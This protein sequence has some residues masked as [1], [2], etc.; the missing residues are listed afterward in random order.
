MNAC[1][2]DMLHDT[3]HNSCCSVRK[4]VHIHLD[5]VFEKFIDE[6][7]MPRR[8]FQCLRHKTFE[9][10]GVI[11]NFHRATTQHVRGAHQ[12]R[13]ADSCRRRERFFR[14]H[15]RV[16]V[17]LVKVELVHD[18]LKAVAVFR[19]VNSVGRRADYRHSRRFQA[20]REIER[21][22]AAKLDDDAVRL[23]RPDDV[24]NIFQRHRLEK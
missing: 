14:V 9:R 23:F 6:N 21:C 8:N 22:L 20:T 16:I 5:G 19:A 1:L 24:Q 10:R 3:G 4:R 12:Y 13:V 11:N 7:R 18:F 15:R 17:R 2:L